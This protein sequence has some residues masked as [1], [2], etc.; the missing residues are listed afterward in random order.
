MLS[1]EGFN[2][3]AGGYDQSV[4]VSDEENSYPFAGYKRVL[5]RIY[6][7]IREMDARQV[8]DIGLGTGILSGRLHRDGCHITGIDFSDKMLQIAREKMPDASLIRHDFSTG[9]PHQ[10]RGEIFDAIIC[11]YAIHHLP[12]PQKPPFLA[13]LQKHLA[14]GG[15]IFIGDV[16]FSSRSDLEACRRISGDEWDDEEFYLVADEILPLFPGA[17]FDPISFCSGILTIPRL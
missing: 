1:S 14:P 17:H 4:R 13:Q 5:G 9:L 8:L 16:A 2:L 3:W 10:L 7:G 12:D 15:K 11:T 6:A